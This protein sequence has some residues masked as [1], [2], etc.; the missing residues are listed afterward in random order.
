MELWNFRVAIFIASGNQKRAAS[1][2]AKAVSSHRTP[3]ND[4]CYENDRRRPNS[5]AQRISR[6]IPA[7]N[8]NAMIASG[9]SRSVT[10]GKSVATAMN[11][12]TGIELTICKTTAIRVNAGSSSGTGMHSEKRRLPK[13]SD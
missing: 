7:L 3:K 9:W 2:N 1:Q 13:S 10:K 12:G 11:C 8:G 5:S 4:P 6:E